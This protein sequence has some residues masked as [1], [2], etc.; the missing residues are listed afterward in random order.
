MGWDQ[1]DLVLWGE[2]R[3]LVEAV[4][5]PGRGLEGVVSEKRGWGILSVR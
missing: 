4:A 3:E 2:H 1:L 5:E